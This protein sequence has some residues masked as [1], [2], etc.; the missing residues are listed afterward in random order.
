VDRRISSGLTPFLLF[1]FFIDLDPF[2][3][4]EFWVILARTPTRSEHYP[5]TQNSE[6][7]IIFSCTHQSHFPKVL[8]LHCPLFP[9]VAS[10][11]RLHKGTDDLCMCNTLKFT[12]LMEVKI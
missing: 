10:R 5:P 1:P 6:E 8:I 3:G 12:Y 11:E 9:C 4:Q 2:Y 7:P